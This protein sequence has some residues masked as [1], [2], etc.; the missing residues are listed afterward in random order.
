MKWIN[1]SKFLQLRATKKTARIFCLFIHYYHYKKT[2]SL[3][4][5]PCGGMGLGAWTI[6]NS[7]G[8]C[9]AKYLKM[10]CAMAIPGYAFDDYF[11]EKKEGIKRWI[12]FQK[13]LLISP[14]RLAKFLPCKK[15]DKRMTFGSALGIG[16]IV[17]NPF[18][19]EYYNKN[20]L[21]F[22]Q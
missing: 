17:W 4:P 19:W 20:S 22:S 5:K 21:I 1:N 14:F 8:K 12:F 15:Y 16:A 9:V 2:C 13:N 11:Y 3:W 18:L 7:A 6:R 10:E